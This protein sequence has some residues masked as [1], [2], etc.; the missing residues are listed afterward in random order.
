M[1]T[2]KNLLL[3]AF[4]ALLGAGM[5]QAQRVPDYDAMS[6]GDLMD[7]RIKV[8]SMKEQTSMESPGVITVISGEEIRTS[9]ARD[10]MD[11]LETVPGFDFGMDVQGVIGL[12]VRGNW[13]HEGKV[14][15]LID[16]QVMNEGLY[17]TLQFGNHYPLNSIKR[18][19]IIRGPGSVVYGD[20]AEYAVINII[21][22]TPQEINGIK[23]S[24][25]YGQM[26]E[27]FARRGGYFS[28]GKKFNNYAYD[29]KGSFIQGNRSD[30]IY[31]DVYGNSYDMTG[32]SKLNNNFINL[33]FQYKTFSIRAISDIYQ[34]TSSDEFQEIS[35]KVHT[36]QFNSYFV[37]A[38]HKLKLSDKCNLINWINYKHQT[39]WRLNNSVGEL[40][41]DFNIT[42]QRFTLNSQVQYDA[43]TAINI[44]SGIESYY[45]Q[46]DNNIS[47]QL[48]SS[49]NRAILS[50]SNTALYGQVLFKNK[51]ANLTLGARQNFNSNYK[52]YFV[53]R[54][55]L[56]KSF[57]SFHFKAMYSMA[58]RAPGAENIDLGKNV[59]PEK[60]GTLEFETGYQ[61][62]KHLYILMNAYDIQTNDPII[63]Y[64]DQSTKLEGYTNKKASGT[65]GIEAE[66]NYVNQRIHF[67]S[68]YSWYS[69]ANKEKLDEYEV[70][71]V[72]KSLL[73]IA[74][75][76]FFM[77]MTGSISRDIS[78]SAQVIAKGK[79]YY[80]GYINAANQP[81]YQSEGGST[82]INITFEW[83]HCL[84]RNISVSTGIYN[85]F[86][87]QEKYIQP[88][89][90][91]HAPL[92]GTGRE[93]MVRVSF[94]LNDSE[95]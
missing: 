79:R 52:G 30:N 28:A 81:V 34:N 78:L 95:K 77:I 37:E 6:L 64:Y 61:I 63:Y 5:A 23:A 90:S 59:K 58:Y 45:D 65:Q 2:R 36:R 56:T 29:I 25:E 17:S 75:Q 21:T 85:V 26:K 68:G 38:K 49:T 12:G 84:H 24:V 33:G 76:K 50:Y 62:N 16:G 4:F 86:N 74:N 9:G 71:D 11:I 94:Q 92:P 1:L 27:S 42:D 47:G 82:K 20:Y 54:I 46:S 88:Y 57:R 7:V 40:P 89:N 3:H 14:L 67:R 43:I 53:P 60:T 8:A 19:E 15:L 69:A 70:P 35:D 87:T 91:L 48:F 18:I 13:A 93:L 39:P 55:C 80:I 41:N 72:N 66:V 51:I 22:E 31:K 10:L 32:N 73:G 83:K 44:I